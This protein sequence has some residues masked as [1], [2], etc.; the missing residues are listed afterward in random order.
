M[1][2]EDV[3]EPGLPAE[4]IDTLR[5]LV[6]CCVPKAREKREKLAPQRRRSILAEDDR[7]QCGERDLGGS[8]RVIDDGRDEQSQS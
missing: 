8:I 6:A 3:V 5:D 7:R 4:L 2:G 1:P